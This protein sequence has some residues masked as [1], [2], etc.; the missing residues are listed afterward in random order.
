MKITLLSDERLRL[1]N[2][3]GPLTIEA[4]S[5]DMSYS[6]FH[7]V[8]SGLATC[9]L[10]VLHSWASHAGIEADSLAIEVAWTFGEKPHRVASYDVR[11]HWPDLAEERMAAA[12][13]AATLCAVHS[14]LAHPPSITVEVK[15]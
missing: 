4:E 1:D 3:P 14:T 7:M 12:S 11:L 8:A 10:A 5:A 9:T 6:P 13:R 15:E 2:T